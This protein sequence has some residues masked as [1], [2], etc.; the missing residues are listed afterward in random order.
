[1]KKTKIYLS[2]FNPQRY[3]SSFFVDNN[4]QDSI[5]DKGYCVINLL[6]QKDVEALLFGYQ[7]IKNAIGGK[8]G[9]NFWPSGRHPSEKIRNLAKNKIEEIVPHKLK[10]LFVKDRY[11]FIGGTYLVKPPFPESNLSPHQDSSH[12]MEDRAFSVYCWIPLTD[13]DEN[14]GCVFVLPS[15][16]KINIKQRSLSVPWVLK[17]HTDII[18]KYMEPVQ[19]K[20]GQ[21][22]LFDAALIHSSLPNKTSETRVAVNYY[23]HKKN[24]PFCHF[25]YN[26]ITKKV[27]IYSVTPDFYYNEDFEKKPNEK[28]QKITEV[29]LAIKKLSKNEVLAICEYI[30][31]SRLKSLKWQIKNYFN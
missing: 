15:S 18:Q 25:Y 6:N 30:N 7:K 17:E 26:E 10:T 31:G 8:F 2:Q 1:M 28:Y 3:S 12:V 16:H 5:K 13:V 4:I 24:H 14:N 20:A 22:L 23:I 11:E 29:D 9:P 19:M 27:E 21:A